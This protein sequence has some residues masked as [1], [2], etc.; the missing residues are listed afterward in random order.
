MTIKLYILVA[1]LL[2]VA[3]P[4]AATENYSSESKLMFADTVCCPPDSLKVI[5]TNYPVFCVR[6]KVKRD[7]ACKRVAAFEVQWKLVAS[8]VWSSQIVSYTS[9]DTVS[10]CQSVFTC[11]LYQWRVRTKCTDSSFSTWT[12]GAK[13]NFSCLNRSQQA[14]SARITTSP[15]PATDNITISM[16]DMPSGKLQLAIADITGNIVISRAIYGSRGQLQE[17]IQ[18]SALRRGTYFINIMADG[19]IK[20]RSI[21]IKQ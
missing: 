4:A 14:S 5:S 13:F 21:F 1:F 7:S 16:G 19:V 6:W 17:R 12:N 8:T 9:G 2:G 15:N 20:A 10:F 3:K 18:V 11:G